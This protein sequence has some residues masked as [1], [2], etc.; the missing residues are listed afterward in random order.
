M[1]RSFIFIA[2]VA[3][4]AGSPAWSQPAAA[5]AA[6]AAPD[7]AC[8]DFYAHVNGVWQAAT[9]LP[10]DRA[11]AGSFTDLRR[12]N[13]RMLK[14]ALA[15]LVAEP[16]RQTT[17]G[18]KRLAAYYRSGIDEAGIAQRGLAAVAPLLARI[19]GVDRAGLPALLGELSRLQ[20]DLPLRLFVGIDAKDATRF[21]VLALQ[22]GLGLPERDDYFKTDETTRRI[23]AGYRLYAQRLLQGAGIAVDDSALEALLALETELA[24]ASM[25]PVQ[26]R[27]P[28]AT[29]NPQTVGGL[30]QGAPGMDWKA[31]LAAYAGEALPESLVLGQPELARALATQVQNAPLLAWRHYLRLR[32]LDGVA[33][34]LPSALAQAHFEYH[35]GVRRGVQ[36]PPPRFERIIAVIGGLNGNAPLGEALGE[37]YVSKAHSAQAQLRARQMV[38][39]I[40][41]AMHAR[42]SRSPWM[43]SATQKQALAKLEAMGALIGS[44]EHWQAYEG[45]RVSSEDFAGNTL[46][47]R[48]WD[49]QR[50]LA[51]LSRPVDRKRWNTSAHTVNAFASAGNR[52]VFPAGILQPPFFDAEA[53]DASNYGAIGSV[54]GH[55]ITHHFDNRGR[56]FDAVGN[57]RDWWQAADAAAYQARTEQVAQLYSGYEPLPGMRINGHQTLGENIS[58][59]GG[60]QIAFDGLQ[61]A[62]QRKRATGEGVPR[63]QGQTPEQRFFLAN[64]RVWRI[65]WREQALVNQLRTGQ[66]SPGQYRV[67]G[68][69]SHMPAFA[70]AFGCK[71]GDP[72]VAPDPIVIW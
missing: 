23:Q 14:D 2:V 27:D 64:A 50:R 18:L 41:S 61:I 68:P 48:Q 34:Q 66:H 55:E 15:E 35:S 44:P 4:Q 20:V 69:I 8:Q 16:S 45:L 33:D 56:Q 37:L 40:R 43:S 47:V 17:P 11:T 26:R 13:D 70:Q 57:L 58:D 25:T 9:E 6:A 71:A 19:D 24:R 22:G 3:A 5:A 30:Q 46:R 52:I 36:S 32:V 67:L 1:L 65:K 49:T 62:L 29:Y 12:N 10:A 59:F 31:W 38:E 63:V 7:S 21:R 53:D 42:I 60:I 72:M 54:I 28:N 51:D 39:D